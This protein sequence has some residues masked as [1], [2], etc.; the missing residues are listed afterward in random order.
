MF[1]VFADRFVKVRGLRLH[2]LE[3]GDP[4]NPAVVLVHGLNG[5]AHLWDPVSRQLTQDYHVICPDLRGHGDSDWSNEGYL[6]SDFGDDLHAI[7]DA[8]NI[9]EFDIVGHSLGCRA[10]LA[11]A[12]L[13]PGGV[14]HIVLSDTGPEVA[15][16]GAREV[17]QRAASL[18]NV[19]GYRSRDEV[20]DDVRRMYPD[21]LEEYQEL[22]ALHQY[23]L[24]WVQ[25]YVPK[26]DPEL[27]WVTGSI[28]RK[29][30]PDLWRWYR[31]ITAPTL[32]MWGRN[33]FL[34]DQDLVDRML[35]ELNSA[36]LVA[37]DTGHSIPYEAP[38]LFISNL[39]RFFE[40]GAGGLQRLTGD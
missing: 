19:R 26:A 27:F 37:L 22:H 2:L 14:R 5:H 32:I 35:S 10:V 13:Y 8:L 29:Q 24:N 18:S 34:M 36:S 3:W 25:R 9:V 15:K 17:Q 39:L 31:G 20:L 40:D 6:Y 21:W 1:L 16:S 33:S 30:I 23:R 12:G 38:D 28:S 7:L 4:D 11:L